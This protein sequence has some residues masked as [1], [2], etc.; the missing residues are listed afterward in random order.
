MRLRARAVP[1]P[2]PSV[3]TMLSILQQRDYVTRRPEGMGHVYR[4]KIPAD[5]TR[6]RILQDI[7]DRAF[8]GSALSLVAAL[9]D[10]KM[11]SRKELEKAKRLIEEHEKR[12]TE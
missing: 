10:A 9:V 7:I 1:S 5:R 2:P 11:V 4:A 8:D 12:A 3:R 6:K